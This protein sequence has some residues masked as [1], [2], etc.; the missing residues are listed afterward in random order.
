MSFVP[1]KTLQDARSLIEGTKCLK[2]ACPNKATIWYGPQHAVC[3]NCAGTLYS[4]ESK[5]I[6]ENPK[7]MIED[8]GRNTYASDSPLCYRHIFPSSSNN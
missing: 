6:P 7:C 1:P 2:N 5:G 8:C 3:E 4:W